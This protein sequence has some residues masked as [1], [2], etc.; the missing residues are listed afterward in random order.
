MYNQKQKIAYN[1][2]RKKTRL[3]YKTVNQGRIKTSTGPG[4]VPNAGPLQT[5]NHTLTSWLDN[6]FW[7][8]LLHREVSIKSSNWSQ[9]LLFN[10]KW[11][12]T[13]GWG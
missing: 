9:N 4:A 12:L 5:Y 3:H 10:N 2:K 6:C 13:F 1:T 7:R 11:E 8:F